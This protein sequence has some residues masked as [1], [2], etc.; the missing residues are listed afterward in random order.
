MTE[1]QADHRVTELEAELRE[2]GDRVW[3]LEQRRTD[4]RA[5]LAD[6]EP[7]LSATSSKECADLEKGLIEA[8][9]LP[10]DVHSRL[11]SDAEQ[12]HQ[13]AELIEK[14][15]RDVARAKEK[16]KE[17]V[18]KREAE[19]ERRIGEIQALKDH[20]RTLE[21]EST[22]RLGAWWCFSVSIQSPDNVHQVTNKG[23]WRVFTRFVEALFIGSSDLVTRNWNSFSRLRLSR[24]QG[25]R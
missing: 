20:V 13:D 9:G 15:T 14:L 19:I 2:S 8:L 3:E 1:R 4:W 21:D 16:R 5:I 6:V 18:L 23:K 12:I 11:Q 22:T 25:K 17:S 24:K 7:I 10:E